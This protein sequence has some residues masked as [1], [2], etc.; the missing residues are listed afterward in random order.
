LSGDPDEVEIA[1][2]ESSPDTEQDNA[3][4]PAQ[5]RE[6]ARTQAQMRREIG[7]FWRKCFA[8]EVGRK[9]LWDLLN[10]MHPFETK[11][12]ASPV[13]FPDERASI[14]YMAEQQMGLRIFLSWQLHDMDGVSLM[15]REHD[16]RL[17]KKPRRRK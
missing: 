11:Y 4:E 7:N 8:D 16:P 2:D 6:R 3:A 14:A 12:G 10:E 15:Q 13:G 9:A 17:P 5:I 1:N